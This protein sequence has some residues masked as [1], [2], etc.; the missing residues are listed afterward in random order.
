MPYK[1]SNIPRQMFYSAVSAEILWI[2]KA[3]I[4]FQD[5]I[6]SAKTMIRRIMQWGLINHM[7]KA[8]LKPFNI[9][10]ALLKP[11]NSY[12]NCLIVL[13]KIIDSILNRPL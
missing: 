8:L 7:E 11:F 1:S 3:T 4:K 5:F 13:G 12:N 6:K 2:C 10:N 9:Y